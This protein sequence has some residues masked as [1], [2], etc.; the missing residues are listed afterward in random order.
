MRWFWNI[1]RTPESR[2]TYTDASVLMLLNNAM[3]NAVDPHALAATE[4]ATGLI[5]RAFAAAAVSGH[6]QQ[7]DAL[8]PAVMG[9]IGRSLIARGEWLAQIEVETDGI[10]RLIPAAGWDVQGGSPDERSWTYALDL[11]APSGQTHV[12]L[13]SDSVVH[14]RINASPSQPWKGRSPVDLA[15]ASASLAAATEKNLTSES[16]IPSSRIAPFPGGLDQGRDQYHKLLATGGV[17]AVSSAMASVAH[18]SGQEPATRWAPQILGA[19]PTDSMVALRSETASHILA[20]C[21][22][23]VEL[24]LASEGTG[25]REAYRRFLHG[26]VTPLARV[27]AVELGNKLDIPNLQFNFDSLFASDIA[28]RARAFQSLVG[29]GMNLIEAAGLAGLKEVAEAA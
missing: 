12:S 7:T 25:A 14:I 6:F 13:T 27:V 22:I 8:T 10:L 29:G 20:A 23:P 4:A 5:S 3:Q 17:H 19:A 21:G 26:T 2:A 9:Q 11:A 28:S 24:F 18:T 1:N 16:K 15:S